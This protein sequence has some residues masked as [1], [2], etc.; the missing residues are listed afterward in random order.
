MTPHGKRLELFFTWRLA[1]LSLLLFHSVSHLKCPD[2]NNNNNN[3]KPLHR[4]VNHVRL[5]MTHTQ[6]Q[7]LCTR[8]SPVVTVYVLLAGESQ[9]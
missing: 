2:N 3:N 9:L 4:Y 8:W 1:M 7:A 5:H 6:I